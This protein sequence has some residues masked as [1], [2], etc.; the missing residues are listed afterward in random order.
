M[1]FRSVKTFVEDICLHQAARPLCLEPHSS[2]GGTACPWLA[3]HVKR[4]LE[5]WTGETEND[6][7]LR[8]G[9]L[10][11]ER[12]GHSFMVP[13]QR[14]SHARQSAIL[15]PTTT[16][17]T[18]SPRCLNLLLAVGSLTVSYLDIPST[19]KGQGGHQRPL[20]FQPRSYLYHYPENFAFGSGLAS[21]PVRLGSQVDY[22]YLMLGGSRR[23]KKDGRLGVD[24]VGRHIERCIQ[25]SETMH[26]L[27]EGAL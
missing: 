24:L 23:P 7:M 12:Q 17:S 18:V 25:T 20:S 15:N 4:R 10:L 19:S 6:V 3:G 11:H 1:W 13:C 21:L 2:A 26:Q 22:Q 27:S 8:G 14:P 9:V 16:L 5:W